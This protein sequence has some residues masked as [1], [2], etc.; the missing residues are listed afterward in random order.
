MEAS[1]TSQ[2]ECKKPLVESEIV[3]A[4]NLNRMIKNNNVSWTEKIQN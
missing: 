3:Q 1:K 2:E 4:T